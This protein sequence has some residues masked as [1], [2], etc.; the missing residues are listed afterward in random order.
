MEREQIIGELRLIIDRH[1]GS[2]DLDILQATSFLIAIVDALRRESGTIGQL[3]EAAHQARLFQVS[4][5][6]DSTHA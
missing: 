2:N 3:A 5:R 1:R 4:L 6:K